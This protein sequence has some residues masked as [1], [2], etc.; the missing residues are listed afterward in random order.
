M[1]LRPVRFCREG[2]PRAHSSLVS[3]LSPPPFKHDRGAG[4]SGH[5]PKY[6]AACVHP[7]GVLA[8]KGATGRATNLLTQNIFLLPLTTTTSPASKSAAMLSG[9]SVAG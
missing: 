6:S 1:P 7:V 2:A 8:C 9:L 4:A 3:P 5:Q